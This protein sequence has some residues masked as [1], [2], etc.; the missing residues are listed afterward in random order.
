[1]LARVGVHDGV[2]GNETDFNPNETCVHEA[3]C[4]GVSMPFILPAPVRA[5]PCLCCRLW[6]ISG[7]RSD[8]RAGVRV[9]A[10]TGECV[11]V[12][13]LERVAR[14]VTRRGVKS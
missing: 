1:M 10:C 4:V 5:R 2:F 9:N 6:W 13:C 3:M 11:T 12:V 7:R 8:A 14:P